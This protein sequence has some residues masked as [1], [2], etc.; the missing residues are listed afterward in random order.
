MSGINKVFKFGG[1]SVKD[2]AAVRNL[3]DIV[4][5]RV[6]EN[7]MLVVSAM[8]KTTNMLE[9]VLAEYRRAGGRPEGE[10]LQTVMD[11]H[12]GI[13]SD[14]FPDRSDPV[15]T[16]VSNLFD[17]LRSKLE[18]V[19]P[20]YDRHYDR[21]V[22]YGELVSTTIVSAYLNRRGIPSAWL[23][24][25][26]LVVTDRCWRSALVDW[27]ETARRIRPLNARY[28]SGSV[29]VVQGFIGGTAD[30]KDSTTLGREGSDY[31]AAI[32]AN[33]L[34]AEEVTIWKDVSGLLNADPKRFSD[35]VKIP[36]ISYSEAIELAF[37]GATIIHPKTIKPLQNKG[38]SL[39]VQSF[40]DPSS[41]PTVIDGSEDSRSFSR[42]A[43]VPS[44]IVKDHQTLVSISPRDYSFMNEH[45]LQ[46]IFA[47]CD[48]LHIHANMMQTSA[49]MLSICFDYDEAKLKGL[50]SRLSDRF[51]IKYN[52]GL[53]LF[54]VRHYRPEGPTPTEKAF[55][56]RKNI[57]VR[58]SSRSTLQYV[59][60][61]ALL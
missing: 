49:L 45:N 56:D 8:G 59:L 27:D 42:S 12:E 48:E 21:T 38:I 40:L 4:S 24:A 46:I 10:P 44:Y 37:Y 25:R 50:L 61:P 18:D 36:R 17:E 1:A 28:K 20:D 43:S 57:M 22:C 19:E 9:K 7:V 33:C 58:Q 51:S 6:E 54:T 26:G 34:D 39:K 14:L 31:T 55:L 47:T 53:Q 3:A 30:G 52:V 60:E 5:D 32:F 41:D 35:T 29:F 16:T 13:M 2:A 11:Y 23:D 15:Y